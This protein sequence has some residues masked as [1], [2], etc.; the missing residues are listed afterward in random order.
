MAMGGD[1][2][3]GSLVVGAGFMV[4]GSLEM[5]LGSELIM[6]G[7]LFVMFNTLLIFEMRDIGCFCFCVRTSL[8]PGFG[9]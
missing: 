5:V 7:S 2:T 3:F 4:T 9:D 6:F 1:G 8:S